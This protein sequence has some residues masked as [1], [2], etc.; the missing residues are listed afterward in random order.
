MARGETDPAD[1]RLG[2]AAKDLG[3]TRRPVEI[4]PVTVHVLA[5]QGHLGD[6]IVHEGFHFGDDR[7]ERTA[8]LAPPH[9]RDDAVAAEV[10]ASH[11]DGHPRAPRVLTTRG[12]VA[13]ELVGLL[14]DVDLSAPLG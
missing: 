5:E 14:E 4:A 9:V 11:R 7:F 10:V 2:D 12:Q 6:A 13:R 3:E 1:A 8:L